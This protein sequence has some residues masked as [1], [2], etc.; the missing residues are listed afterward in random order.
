MIIPG[1]GNGASVISDA[2]V[3]EFF[4]NAVLIG[5][6]TSVGFDMYFNAYGRGIMGNVLVCARVSYSLLND[7]TTRTSYIPQLNGTP[8]RARDIIRN[9]GAEMPGNARPRREFLIMPDSR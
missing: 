8:M 2:D 7:M 4:N 1:T 5:S 9:S 3:T 6:S